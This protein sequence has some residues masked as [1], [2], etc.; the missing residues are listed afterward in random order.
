[1]CIYYSIAIY[2]STTTT[3]KTQEGTDGNK[4]AQEQALYSVRE[5]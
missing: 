4:T 1:M 5:C 2:A 3:N